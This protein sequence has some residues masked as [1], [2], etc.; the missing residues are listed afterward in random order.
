MIGRCLLCRPLIEFTTIDEWAE[1]EARHRA[2]ECRDRTSEAR[3]AVDTPYL[4]D[5]RLRPLTA[6][7]RA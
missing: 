1:H 6:E 5:V 2:A 7:E 3:L 4:P